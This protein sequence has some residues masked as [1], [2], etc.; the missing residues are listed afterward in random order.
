MIYRIS[1]RT[2]YHYQQPANLCHNQ[3]RV[4]PRDLP[5]QRCLDFKLTVEPRPD[6]HSS[7]T[8]G[9]GNHIDYFAIQRPHAD[10]IITAQ[11]RVEVLPDRQLALG[12]GVPWDQAAAIL[13]RATDTARIDAREFVLPSRLIPGSPLLRDFALPDFTPGRPLLEAVTALNSRIF[14]EFDF[15]PGF[16]TVST[17]VLEVLENKAGVCQDFA[18]LMIGALRAIGLPARYV[19]GY[20]ETLPPPGK[21]K[22]VGADASHAWV[23]VF[24]PDQGWVDFDPTNNLRPGE[25][26]IVTAIGRDYDDVAPL[27][28]ITVGG[29]KHQLKVSVDVNPE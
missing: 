9:F 6:F 29:A 8:D 24:D 13:H 26:H 23:S 11:S 4:R 7:R 25:R 5:G 15:T 17:P 2:K 14:H 3:A 10:L 12:S 20:L 21:T 16:T 22:L 1:H 18:Q 27:R 28:G 19:S